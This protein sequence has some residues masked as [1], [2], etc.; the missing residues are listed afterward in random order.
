[1]VPTLFFILIIGY[2]RPPVAPAGLLAASVRNIIFGYC[3]VS[4][5]ALPLH[6]DNPPW[7]GQRINP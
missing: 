1:M 7:D 5:F 6:V 4:L 3:V 2:V